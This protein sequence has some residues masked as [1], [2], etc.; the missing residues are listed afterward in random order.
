MWRRRLLSSG[1]GGQPIRFRKGPGKELRRER[2]GKDAV[3]VMPD[4]V[5]HR[6]QA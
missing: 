3:S 5:L 4:T 6:L 2:P 1:S